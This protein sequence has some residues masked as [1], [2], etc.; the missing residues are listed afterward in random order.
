MICGVGSTVW[1]VWFPAPFKGGP[2]GAV[3]RVLL[4]KLGTRPG[5]IWEHRFRT[6]RRKNRRS[7]VRGL[8]AAKKR[9]GPLQ[10]ELAT[11]WRRYLLLVP[12]MNTGTQAIR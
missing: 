11:L 3:A 4:R 10:E 12:L 1:P 6:L 8:D 9:S 2:H 7:A 5:A